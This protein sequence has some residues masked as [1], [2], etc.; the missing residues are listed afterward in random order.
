M[1]RA[2]SIVL[3]IVC[4]CCPYVQIRYHQDPTNSLVLLQI[5]HFKCHHVPVRGEKN[6]THTLHMVHSMSKDNMD[7][8]NPM[9]LEEEI[10]PHVHVGGVREMV[11]EG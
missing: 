3:H 2:V 4:T 10:R 11:D 5:R 9:L 1:V 8:D 7:M 6:N